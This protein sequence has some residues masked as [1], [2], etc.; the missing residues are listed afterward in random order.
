MRVCVPHVNPKRQPKWDRLLRRWMDRY[1]LSGNTWPVVVLTDLRTRVPD[2]GQ[3]RTIPMTLPSEFDGATIAESVGWMKAAAYERVGPCFVYDSDMWF[4]KPL[5]EHWGQYNFLSIPMAM[6]EDPASRFHAEWP[7]AS[8]EQNAG[9]LWLNSPQLLSLYEKLWKEKKSVGFALYDQLIFTAMCRILMG[10]TLP[11]IFNWSRLWK[12]HPAAIAIHQH[13]NSK[14]DYTE[15]I[16]EDISKCA[17]VGNGPVA[18]CGSEIEAHTAVIRLN[19]FV[20]KGFE[21]HAGRKTTHWCTHGGGSIENRP[22]SPPF[23][24]YEQYD[25]FVAPDRT[26]SARTGKRML[27]CRNDYRGLMCEDIA[28]PTT[29]FL[30]LC[31]LSAL[32]VETRAYGFDF[33]RSGHYWNKQYQHDPQHQQSILREEEI[34]RALPF[35]SFRGQQ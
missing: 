23:S 29:G 22:A 20:T 10:P 13:G 16:L 2:V 32:G 33:L 8:P 7:E 18:D 4:Q 28:R 3:E 34:A 14:W 5:T 15:E 9:A 30:L 11:R 25:P 35:V 12:R 1:R 17:V 24:P 31:V 21:E 19:N 26:L 6:G 27:Y